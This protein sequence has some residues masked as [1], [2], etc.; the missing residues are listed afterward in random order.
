[1]LQDGNR[2]PLPTV[3]N[4]KVKV[5]AKIRTFNIEDINKTLDIEKQAFPKT[6]YPKEAFLSY[7]DRFPDRFVVIECDEDILGYMIF[8]TDG[9]IHSMAVKPAHR[10]QGLG[11]M[12]FMHAARCAEKRLWLEVRS[13]NTAAIAF[14]RRMGMEIDGRIQDYYE[15]DDA[16]MMVLSESTK[17]ASRYRES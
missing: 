5:P 11:T 17:V 6:A 14:Y 2:G 13:R 7:A 1:M 3:S 4:M 16:L 8:D 12:L 9:H 15:D 10:R